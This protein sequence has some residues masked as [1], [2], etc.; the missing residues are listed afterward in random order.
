MENQTT[1]IGTTCLVTRLRND[2]ALLGQHGYAMPAVGAKSASGINLCEIG[3]RITG[4]RFLFAQGRSLPI[5]RGS[6]PVYQD[7]R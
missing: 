7:D 2:S 6:P 4:P 3:V 1:T 5:S